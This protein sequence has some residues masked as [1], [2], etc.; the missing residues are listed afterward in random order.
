MGVVANPWKI[1]AM[2]DCPT[3]KDIKALRGFFGLIG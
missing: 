2:L 1:D 3:P